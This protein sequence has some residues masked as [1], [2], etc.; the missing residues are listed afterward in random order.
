M[1]KAENRYVVSA[2]EGLRPGGGGSVF[3]SSKENIING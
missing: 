2:I 1:D 3:L